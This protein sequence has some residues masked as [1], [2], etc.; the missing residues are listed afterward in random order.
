VI[1]LQFQAAGWP[2]SPPASARWSAAV[3]ADDSPPNTAAAV[4]FAARMVPR[5][6]ATRAGC[7][8]ATTTS[9]NGMGT[10]DRPG[11]LARRSGRA[12]TQKIRGLGGMAAAALSAAFRHAQDAGSTGPLD[13]V[14]R[15]DDR[16]EEVGHPERLVDASRRRQARRGRAG[17]PPTAP[18]D[19]HDRKVRVMGTER[20]QDLQALGPADTV[21]KH[22][23]GRV[24]PRQ[25]GQGSVEIGGLR[26]LKPRARE[27]LYLRCSTARTS[28]GSPRYAA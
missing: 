26:A 17:L 12:P 8:H 27:E 18:G 13:A 3:S 1:A 16:G 9:V 21:V 28:Q 15:A 20:L 6:S 11:R 2:R 19:E 7:G 14:D 5:A 22:D 24:V 23:G 10:W 25:S 4:P